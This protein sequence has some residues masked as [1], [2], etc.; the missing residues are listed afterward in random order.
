[1]IYFKTE[2]NGKLVEVDVYDDEF[3]S[4]C[5]V[6]GKEMQVSMEEIIDIYR[7]GGDLVSTSLAHAECAG[8]TR[9][10]VINGGKEN[11]PS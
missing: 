2:V 8:K 11:S 7:N 6:C 3:Y 1:M 5:F 10:K 9:F 4:R